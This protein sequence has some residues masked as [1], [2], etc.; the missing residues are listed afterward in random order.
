MWKVVPSEW[1]LLRYRVQWKFVVSSLSRRRMYIVFGSKAMV[2]V[3]L[4]VVVV[5]VVL[6]VVNDIV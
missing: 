1:G 6:V 5:I 2:V 3:L 4:Q